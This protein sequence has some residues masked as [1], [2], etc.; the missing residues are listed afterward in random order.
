MDGVEWIPLKLWRL[1]EHLRCKQR[2]WSFFLPRTETFALLR[3]ELASRKD[4]TK[5]TIARSTAKGYTL[6]ST[7]KKQHWDNATSNVVSRSVT[8]AVMFRGQG[9][10]T[11]AQPRWTNW[12]QN[13]WRSTMHTR[14]RSYAISDSALHKRQPCLVSKDIKQVF[15]PLTKILSEKILTTKSVPILQ[16]RNTQRPHW[17]WSRSTLTRPPLTR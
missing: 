4:P 2:I 16:E 7:S 11:T 6:T 5:T 10:T 9:K 14:K 17:N 8:S 12:S 3:V 13:W 1:I 15:R